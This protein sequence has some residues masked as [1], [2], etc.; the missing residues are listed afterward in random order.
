MP[1]TIDVFLADDHPVFRKGLHQLFSDHQGFRVLGTAANGAE[2]LARIPELQPHIAVLD[3]MMPECTGIEVT[4]QLQAAEVPTRIVLLTAHHD[5][6]VLQQAF[7]SGAAGL[8]PKLSAEEEILQAVVTVHAGQRYVSPQLTELLLPLPQEPSQALNQLTPA[9]WRVLQ[10]ISREHT[11]RQI[12]EQL[13]VSLKT[14]ENHR[15]NI[16]RKLQLEG[17]NSLLRFALANAEML[18]RYAAK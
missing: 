11:S 17:K 14:I 6:L 4:Q 2:A 13:F 10:A 5:R 8:V 15:S 1:T 16:C 12:A 7:A 18:K 3:V 9:E